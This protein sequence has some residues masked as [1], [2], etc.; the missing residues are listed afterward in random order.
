MGD[1]FVL[2]IRHHGPG[3]ARGVAAALDELCPD[4]VL[5]EG[6]PELD[7]VASLAASAGMRPPVAGLVYA[8]HQP[9]RAVFYPLA[10]FSP[11]WVALRWALDRGAT[12]RFADLPASALLADGPGEE[13]T[14]PDAA[15][16][17][18][19][20]I[21]TL[22]AAA[23]FD[24]PERW[25][26]DA[27]EH[28]H[29]GLSAFAAVADAMTALR[30]DGAIGPPDGEANERREAAMRRMLRAA[31][32]DHDRVVFVCGAWH[33]PAVH[34][35][36]FPRASQDDALLKGL[37]KIKVAATW[38]PWT[39]RRLS[40]RSGYGAG[41]GSPGWYEHLFTAP[42]DVPA[43]W[44][45]RTANLLREEQLDASSASVIEAVRLAE[46]LATLR[47]RPLAG[48]AE[49][50]DATEA[51]LCAGS[52]VPMQLVADRLFVGDELGTVP[53][54]TPMVPLAQ[55]L[56]RQQKR[57][58]LKPTAAEQVVVLDL[59][60]ES[61][62]ERSQ[63]LHRLALLGVGWGDQID[64]GRT[65]GTFKEAWRLEWR[66]ELAL[67]LIDAS[68]AGTT[69]EEAA[70]ATV[71]QRAGEADIA[72]LTL[73]VEQ[74]LLANLPA[75]L[76]AA[77]DALEKRSARQHDTRRLMA[78]VEPLARLSRYG[79]VRRVDTATVLNV[80][81]GI[82]VRVAIGLGAACSS[83]DDDAAAEMRKLVDEVHHGLAMVDEAELRDGWYGA[84]AGVA[85][86][87][88][89]H[90]AVAG[91]AIRLLLDAGRLSR[92]EASRRLSLNLS[93][94]AEAVNGAAWLEGFLSGDAALLL[95]DDALLAVIDAWITTVPTELF[96]D[97]LP[98]V[99]RMFSTFRRPERRMIGEKVRHLDGSGVAPTRTAG[100]DGI[101]EERARRAL[102][103]LR[104]ILGV[105][106]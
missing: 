105:G 38:V 94:G 40:Y 104:Q 12:I 99:R 1:V 74:A 44:L 65:R 11:E 54:E 19:D 9:H 32:K 98:L 13:R 61:H 30:E 70:A 16:P 3:S 84:L 4:A 79:N 100:E 97:L 33:A 75:S 17:P 50:T 86:Q 21:S 22:A 15:E 57:L 71:V 20:P 87:E 59:R 95:H 89:V 34:P 103:V 72:E 64:P 90:G 5:I 42:G 91:R 39:N 46:A 14:P 77:M 10:S 96:D 28:R 49:L 85:D 43:R 66:P 60:T 41:V 8:P 106:P 76:D 52:R 47:G 27:I 53:P 7:A 25:W 101:D 102:P 36:A 23:G 67:A 56:E 92:D 78:A 48:L 31:M 18:A 62:L 58:R 82:A 29:H 2:G 55:D 83:L 69:I 45:V 51:A 35:D 37:P 6:A 26:E 68:G 73:L 80:L 88:G 63:L 93:R 24:D 81:R